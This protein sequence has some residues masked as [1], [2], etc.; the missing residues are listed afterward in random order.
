MAAG[1]RKSA[2]AALVAALAGGLTVEAAAQK[3]GVGESTVY[4][5][6]REP[7]FRAR[8]DE[9]RA[10]VVRG[11]IGQLSRLG[12]AAAGVLARLMKDGPEQVQLG[13]TRTALE[14]LFKGHEQYNLARQLEE[15][16]A[17]LEASRRHGDGDPGPAGG[18]AA[19]NGTGE[20]DGGEPAAE[21]DPG[22]PGGGPAPGGGGPGR[23]ADSDRPLF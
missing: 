9:A 22:G 4:R 23:V 17:E 16:R 11:V 8:L 10:E 14:Y 12:Q 3:A 20:R 6:L 18:P 5:R 13:A 1:G 21:D 7:A 2:D 19:G 15:L